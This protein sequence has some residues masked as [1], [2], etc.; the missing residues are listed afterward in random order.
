M[1]ALPSTEPCLISG[2]A[3]ILLFRAGG[4]LPPISSVLG[5][6]CPADRRASP[7]HGPGGVWV[8]LRRSTTRSLGP[9]ILTLFRNLVAWLSQSQ[10]FYSPIPQH[11]D[12]GE[13]C[14]GL[15]LPMMGW[16]GITDL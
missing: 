1:T 7:S 12:L 6:E 10:M 15:P 11:P 4:R 3:M 5:E 9:T 16:W 2:Q 13:A 8:A 14:G